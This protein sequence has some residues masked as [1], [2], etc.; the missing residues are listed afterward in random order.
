MLIEKHDLIY[1]QKDL[2]SCSSVSPSAIR[3]SWES[4]IG[5]WMNLFADDS[6]TPSS[7][8]RILDIIMYLFS[9]QGSEVKIT[10]VIAFVMLHLV[11]EE[12]MVTEVGIL[13]LR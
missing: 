13:W 5:P 8:S 7:F 9:V 4:F 1:D 3:N 10:R 2:V 11:G 12:M 6:F